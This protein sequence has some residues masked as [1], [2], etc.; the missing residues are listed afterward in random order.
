MVV[1]SFYI[2][3]RHGE[4]EKRFGGINTENL[5]RTVSTSGDGCLQPRRQANRLGRFQRP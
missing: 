2:F 5:Q 3:D 1:Y 4:S